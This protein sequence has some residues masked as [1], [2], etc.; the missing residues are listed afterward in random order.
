MSDKKHRYFF[1]SFTP[2]DDPDEELLIVG[3]KSND[4]THYPEI[5][6]VIQ[7]TKARDVYQKLI[8]KENHE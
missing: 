5:I 1:V 3:K 7:G 4:Y 6:N 8:T 2:N